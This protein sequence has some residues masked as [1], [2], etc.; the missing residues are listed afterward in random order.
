MRHVNTAAQRYDAAEPFRR[1]QCE[2][3]G[4]CAAHTVTCQ[5]YPVYIEAC[6][7]I[8]QQSEQITLHLCPVAILAGELRNQNIAARFAQKSF[9]QKLWKAVLQ[10]KRR[11]TA[12]PGAAVQIDDQL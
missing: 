7:N 3:P 1:S 2:R 11:I 6:R 10:D 5:A 9:L 12:F 8:V 4:G